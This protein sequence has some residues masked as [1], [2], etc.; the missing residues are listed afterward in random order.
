MNSLAAMLPKLFYT[1]DSDTH[2]STIQRMHCC[3]PMATVDM[4]MCHNNMLYVDCLSCLVSDDRQCPNFQSQVRSYAQDQPETRQ[5]PRQVN[6]LA[7][8]KTDILWTFRPITGL[9]KLFEGMC[10]NC[11]Y[12][13]EKFFHLWKPEYTSTIFPNIPILAPLIGRHTRQLPGWPA[14]YSS[15]AYAIIRIIQAAL[16][17]YLLSTWYFPLSHKFRS[18]ITTSSMLLSAPLWT[19]S[20]SSKQ[21]AVCWSLTGT[22]H[23]L[24]L[25][26]ASL[27][28]PLAA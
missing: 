25:L 18:K 27:K 20:S 13:S 24:R 2:S 26:F 23:Q 12:F 16:S 21:S 7:P 28:Q 10:P 17:T 1:V 19:A 14:P 8:L 9:E 22:S 5:H 3:L 6:N 11:R 4:Q 15:P